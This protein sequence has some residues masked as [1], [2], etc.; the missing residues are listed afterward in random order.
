MSTRITGSSNANARR[1]LRWVPRYRG[2]RE[3]F[4]EALTESPASFRTLS[5][6]PAEGV[7]QIG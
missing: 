1:E 6:R 2:W 4:R 7:E 3:G 5:L